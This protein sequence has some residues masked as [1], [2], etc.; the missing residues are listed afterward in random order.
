[1]TISPHSAL[2]PRDAFVVVPIV[3]YEPPPREIQ[4][5]RPVFPATLRR[6]PPRAPR[7]PCDR[8]P[9]ANA[10]PPPPALLPEAA[11]FANAA[12]RAVLEVIDRRRPATA[13]RPLL[14]PS[15]ID[16]VLSVGRAA[17]LAPGSEGAGVL[18]RVRLQAVRRDSPDAAV[19][20]FGSYSR[21]SRV[22]AIAG[23]IEQ[24]RGSAGTRWLV[25]ALHIG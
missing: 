15:L 4:S 18:R 5:R 22:H 3:E 21:G 12:L 17:G 13:L 7:R 10:A 25:V 6:H 19:E 11:A 16:S 14:V 9:S 24:V 8:Q 23:R 20:V 2:S 1:M